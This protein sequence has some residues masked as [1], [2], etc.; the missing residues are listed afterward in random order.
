MVNRTRIDNLLMDNEGPEYYLIPMMAIDN[1]F[2]GD[3]I[4]ICQI[5]VEGSAIHTT[6]SS[7]KSKVRLYL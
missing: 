4:V 7:V 2:S 1:V 6:L 5:N 3:N